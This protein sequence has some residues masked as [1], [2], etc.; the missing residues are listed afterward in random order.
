MTKRLLIV[1]HVPSPNTVALRDAAVRGASSADVN[2][3]EVVSKTQF[4][5]VAEDAPRDVARL[6]KGALR[7]RPGGRDA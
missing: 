6:A 7:G 1:A 2:G 4:E 3:V 5:A